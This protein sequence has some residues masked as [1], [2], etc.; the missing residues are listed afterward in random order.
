MEGNTTSDLWARGAAA[1]ERSV[2]LSGDAATGL[3][4][5]LGRIEQLSGELAEARA[6]IAGL[7]YALTTNRRIGQAIGIVMTRLMITETEAFEH[8]RLASQRSHRK[9]REIAEEIV[10]TGEIPPAAA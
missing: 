6:K 10:Y 5:A 7:E 9:L 3:A 2:Q 4:Q 8:L 1:R